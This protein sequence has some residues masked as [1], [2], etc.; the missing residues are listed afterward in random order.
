MNEAHYGDVEKVLPYI[1]EARQRAER[2]RIALRR[3][4]AEPHLIQAL[5]QSDEQLRQEHR[6]LLQST[7]YAIP[8]QEQ[9]AV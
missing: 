9:L 4:G 1:S 2:A 6:R 5:T 8:G 3:A 7:F